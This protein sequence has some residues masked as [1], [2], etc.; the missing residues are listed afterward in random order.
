MLEQTYTIDV[1]RNLLVWLNS[2]PGGVKLNLELASIFCDGFLWGT[3]LWEDGALFLILHPGDPTEL[4]GFRFALSRPPSS[5]TSPPDYHLPP[6][7]LWSTGHHHVLLARLGSA[8]PAHDTHLL[9]LS[10]GHITIPMAF[11]YARGP[12]QHLQR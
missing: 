2:W 1:L 4:T 3:A 8:V 6:R 11:E 10:H 12:L 5:T 7:S 9:L